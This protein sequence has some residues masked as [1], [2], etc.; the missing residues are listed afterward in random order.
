VQAGSY[1]ELSS[2]PGLF[3]DLIRRQVA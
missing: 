2:Q 1:D 3:A